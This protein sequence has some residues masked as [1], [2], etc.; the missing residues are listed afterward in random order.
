MCVRAA[1]VVSFALSARRWQAPHRVCCGVITITQALESIL[2]EVTKDERIENDCRAALNRI[3]T[4]VEKLE[5]WREI[6]ELMEDM[7]VVVEQVDNEV[8]WQM[9]V[10]C[11]R[12]LLDNT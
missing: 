1:R 5:A 6:G 10:R 9:S 2:W 7:V 8:R 11:N 4:R 3:V 12:N